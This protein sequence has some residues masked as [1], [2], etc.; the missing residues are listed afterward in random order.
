MLCIN[1]RL[2]WKAFVCGLFLAT[3]TELDPMHACTTARDVIFSKVLFFLLSL[4][5]MRGFCV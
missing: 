1:H 5:G 4:L 2:A 3:L